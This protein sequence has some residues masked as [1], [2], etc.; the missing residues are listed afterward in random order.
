MASKASYFEGWYLVQL[1]WASM[2]IA[3]KQR[4]AIF[5]RNDVNELPYLVGSVLLLITTA[6]ALM[7][8]APKQHNFL[9]YRYLYLLI[10]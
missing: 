10:I 2:S 5:M 3:K 6:I 7:A 4:I 1:A 9:A 8:I